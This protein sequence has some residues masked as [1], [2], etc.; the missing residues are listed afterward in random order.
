MSSY[1]GIFF[2]GCLRNLDLDESHCGMNGHR[3]F[4][5]RERQ[6]NLH[7][8]KEFELLEDVKVFLFY[9]RHFVLQFHYDWFSGIFDR[10]GWLGRTDTNAIGSINDGDMK[11]LVRLDAFE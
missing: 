10:L 7:I 9:K 11:S 2:Y 4:F 5:I 1:S 6:C 3:K 8:F